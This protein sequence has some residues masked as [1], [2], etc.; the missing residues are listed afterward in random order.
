MYYRELFIITMAATRTSGGIAR[1]NRQAIDLPRAT[2]PAKI[3]AFRS[4]VWDYWK[5]GGRHT[6][7]WRNTKDP[8]RIL[9]SEIML[10]QTQVVRVI[11]KYKSFLKKFPTVR[12]LAQA[13]RADV[14]KEWSGLGYNRRGKYLHD[15]AKE[16][17]EKYSGDFKEALKH[18]LPGVGPYTQAAVRTFAFHEPSALIETNIRTVLIQYFFNPSKWSGR[19]SLMGEGKGVSDKEILVIAEKVAKGQESRTWHWALMDYGA[20]LKKNGVRNNFRSA[21][22]TKQ[23]KFE[24]SV[25]QV[26]GEVLRQL[27]QTPL[28]EKALEERVSRRR[29]DTRKVPTALAGLQK[30]NLV[31]KEKGKWRIA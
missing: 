17:V 21:H 12:A 26:R 8:Y 10:Q 22:Y 24:G 18:P 11:E 13:S 1:K 25:R 28:S 7:P 23:S 20:N 27:H 19:P 31:K 30:D 6:L 5:K 4:S 9:V 14:L 15:T 3:R 16:V 29:L 2:N